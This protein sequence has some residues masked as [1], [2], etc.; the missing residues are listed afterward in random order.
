M[1]LYLLLVKY[2]NSNENK[3]DYYIMYKYNNLKFNSTINPF[4]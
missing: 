2:S 3:N 1:I 4:D